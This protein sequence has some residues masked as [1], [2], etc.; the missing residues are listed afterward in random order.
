MK[1]VLVAAVASALVALVVCVVTRRHELV[2][3]GL[4]EAC[5]KSHGQT[6]WRIK[7]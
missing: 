2:A 7:E 4:V 6:V 1:I 3:K 5:G